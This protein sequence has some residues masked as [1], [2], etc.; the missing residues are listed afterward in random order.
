MSSHDPTDVA[1]Q[2]RDQLDA[3]DR[4]QQAAR[5]EAEDIKWLASSKR[6][7]RIIY[8]FLERAGVWRISFD[9]NALKMAFAEGRRNEGNA[10]IALINMHCPDR[11][12]DMIKEQS[13]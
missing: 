6:G 5:L 11:Y 10:L 7:R 8:R 1:A 4:A 13:E 12:M 2:E 3:K 9:A